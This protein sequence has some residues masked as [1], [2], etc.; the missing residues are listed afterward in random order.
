[1]T[2]KLGAQYDGKVGAGHDGVVQKWSGEPWL[3]KS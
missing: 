3:T 2:G 1:M